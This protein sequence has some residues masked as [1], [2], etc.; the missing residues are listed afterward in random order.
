MPLNI[1]NFGSEDN[2]EIFYYKWSPE[3]KVKGIVQIIH[4]MAEHAFRYNDF[5]EFLIRNGFGVYA[6]DHRGHGKTKENTIENI[7]YLA[8][9]DGWELLVNDVY[10]LTKIIKK[11][12][13]ET[14]VF[15]LGHSMGAL[16][17]RDYISKYGNEINGVILSGV[18]SDPGLMTDIALMIA[19]FEILIKG[20]KKKS[21]LLDKLSFGKYNSQFKPNRTPYD[22]LSRDNAI[23]DRY[24][25][26]KFCGEIF[27]NTFFKDMLGGIKEINKLENIS[28]VPKDLGMYFICGKNDPVGDNSKGVKK[29]YKQYEK[30]NIKNLNLKIYQASRHEILN[31][32]NKEEV[33]NDILNWISNSC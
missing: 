6:N 9:K 10:A 15:I 26:D 31:E 20:N 12:N 17:A 29:I 11:E 24:V 13:P 4:G 18:P 16:I 22:F 5:A 23:V 28:K 1:F 19:N 32:L 27:T 2:K 25:A 30:Q 33:Y 8:P 21:P 14:P 3:Q 7:G